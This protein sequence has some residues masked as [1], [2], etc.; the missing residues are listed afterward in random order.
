MA[1][2]VGTRA[3][4]WATRAV[5]WDPARNQLKRGAYQA[6]KVRGRLLEARGRLP[7]IA[8]IY[9]ASS[10]KAG[11]QWVKALFDHPLVR[12]ETR[13][14]TVPQLDFQSHPERGFPLASF[15]PGLYVSYDEYLRIPHRHP[16][17]VVYMFRD[18]RD[19]VVSGYFSSIGNHRDTQVPEIEEGRRI[20][21]ELPLDEGLLYAVGAAT[22]RLREMATWSDVVRPEVLKL[23]L[24]EVGADEATAI[25]QILDHCEIGLAGAE[26]DQVIRECSREQLQ[27]KD[28]AAHGDAEKG[29]YRV[30]R[31]T[32]RELFGPE[33]H[34]AV[35]EA[36]PGLVERLG[37]PPA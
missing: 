2:A 35:A 19:I 34:A 12:R 5:Q 4:M 9:A 37:Y 32:Y 21:R 30:D 28:I 27:A 22:T 36:V 15:V 13:L 33:H 23:K 6:A 16:H 10:P 25:R 1:S 26:L 3:R 31:K 18:P 17:R 29:H 7:E 8:N 20:M 11:S 14:F 24:E